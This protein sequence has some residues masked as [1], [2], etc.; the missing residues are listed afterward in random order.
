MDE[1]SPSHQ[2]PA[3]SYQW[4][5]E[6]AVHELFDRVLGLYERQCRG[7]WVEKM[8]RP[9]G[10]TDTHFE[11]LEDVA[12]RLMKGV[13]DLARID[14]IPP[15]V[16]RSLATAARSCPGARDQLFAL[17]DAV[18]IQVGHNIIKVQAEAEVRI[19][20]LLPLV[21]RSQPGWRVRDFLRRVSRCYIY[22]FD[23]E[24]AVMCRSVLEAE[25]DEQISLDDCIAALGGDRRQGGPDSPIYDFTDRIAVATTLGRLDQTLADKANRV[26]TIANNLLHR[27]PRMRVDVLTVI[28]DA[29]D[30]IEALGEKAKDSPPSTS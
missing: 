6:G 14:A 24:C 28:E 16:I 8:G 26:R 22:G 4:Y 19:L 30:V 27:K 12:D 2:P 10:R 13:G 20:K 11:I 5:D 25:L 7:F 3:P 1:S 17:V 23:T 21:R 29:L 9:K 18:W 15:E